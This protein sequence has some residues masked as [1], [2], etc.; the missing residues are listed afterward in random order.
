MGILA[1][2]VVAT[3]F[4]VALITGLALGAV[5]GKGK[6]VF[7]DELLTALFTTLATQQAVH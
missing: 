1:V 4:L 2:R 3:W 6:R 7:N 5:I